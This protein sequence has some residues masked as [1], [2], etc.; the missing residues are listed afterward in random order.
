MEA[1]FS[2]SEKRE[3]VRLEFSSPLSYKV[4]K[5]ET[6][7]TLLNGYTSNISESGILC[8]INQLVNNNDIL[9][10][11]FDRGVLAICEDL[12]RKTMIYQGGIIGKVVRILDKEDGT[13]EIGLRFI[14]REEEKFKNVAQY[15]SILNEKY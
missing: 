14:T 6:I 13:Y 2:G 11:S 7:T 8:S 1:N 10:L 9:W 5:P 3:F 4:C 15:T 12:E